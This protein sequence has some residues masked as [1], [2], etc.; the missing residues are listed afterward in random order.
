MECWIADTGKLKLSGQ[1]N[2][3]RAL[4]PSI[5]RERMLKYI[6][7]EDSLRYATGRIMIRALAARNGGNG[8][9]DILS[10]EYG[11]P[12]Y[13]SEYLP[14]FNLS[15]SG[16]LVVLSFGDIPSGIDVEQI[17][18]INWQEIMTFFGEKE[19]TVLR[20]S[21]RPLEDFYRIWTIR[22]AFSKE[23]GLGL[24]VYEKNT[25][26]FDYE[27]ETVRYSGRVYRFRTIPLS[28]YMLSVC[29]EDLE[30]LKLTQISE[31]MW[32]SLIKSIS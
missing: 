7:P 20:S 14:H 29:A 13:A 27:T 23:E 31:T 4:L 2:H 5:E 19:Q 32:N 10:G 17:K 28:G 22:E 25:V 18:D 9:V 8:N 30:N 15:H 21:E 16:N 24:S 12:Y 26:D 1:L 3:L 6:H 11:K